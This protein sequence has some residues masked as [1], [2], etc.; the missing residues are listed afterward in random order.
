M[1]LAETFQQFANAATFK[2]K[3]RGQMNVFL[4][5]YH[6][7]HSTVKESFTNDIHRD[8]VILG[9]RVS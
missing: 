5:I 3:L 2:Y 1:K 6:F 4:Q 7:I 9:H 8:L